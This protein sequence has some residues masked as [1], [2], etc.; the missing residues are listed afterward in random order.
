M[1]FRQIALTFLVVG[2][3]APALAAGSSSSST[4]SKQATPSSD[5]DRAVS[6]VDSGKFAGALTLLNKVVAKDPRNADAWNYIGF[7]R[8]NLKQ[9]DEA[10]AAYDRALAIDP[11]HRGA[12]EYL[13]ELFL[14]TGNLAKAKE[15]LDRLDKLCLF[16]CDEYDDLEEGI[17]A[18]ESAGNTN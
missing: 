10:L 8:R 11:N 5:Y 15:Q 18:F 16:G 17:K 12:N 7:S 4:T 9:Y 14:M 3:I 13:G 2:W 1:T 6:A